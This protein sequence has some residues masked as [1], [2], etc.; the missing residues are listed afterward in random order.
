VAFGG[1]NALLIGW[2]T[3]RF[4]Y[5]CA[6]K[7]PADLQDVVPFARI[8]EFG[9]PD[10]DDDP[11]VIV[12]SVSVDW[13]GADW[14]SAETLALAGHRAIRRELPGRAFGPDAVVTAVRT[15]SLPSFVPWDD[16]DVVR[17]TASYRLFLKTT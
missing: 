6:T 3:G 9:G 8:V 10:D 12:P 16:T 5:R 17:F 15:I 1:V 2:A 7:T 11:T 4:G 13:F 14:A